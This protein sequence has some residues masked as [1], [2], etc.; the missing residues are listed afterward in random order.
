MDIVTYSLRECDQAISDKYYKRAAVFADEVLREAG[1]VAGSIMQHYDDFLI[2]TKG[3]RNNAEE[4]ILEFLILGVLMRIYGTRALRLKKLQHDVLTWVINK[5]NKD[6]RLKPSMSILKGTMSTLF[7]G[8]SKKLRGVSIT[9]NT[10][11]FSKLILWLEASGEFCNEAKRLRYWEEYINNLSDKSSSDIFA[12]AISFA[13]WFEHR[14]IEVLGEYTSHVDKYLERIIS[15]NAWREDII[16]RERVR[17]EY[18]LNM[19]GAEIMN[20]AFRKAFIS[21]SKKVLLLPLCMTSPGRSLCRAKDFGRSF[22]CAACSDNCQVNQLSKLG[23]EYGFTVMVVPHESSVAASSG[24]DAPF[25]EG[26]GV[27][28][29]ACVL[30]LISGGWLLKDMGVPAQCVLL[31]YCGCRNHWHEKGISTNISIDK[32]KKILDTG[33][34]SI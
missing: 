7:L 27:I 16:F 29:V 17:A 32:L 9:H 19:V 2:N 18:H 28:G 15:R 4:S 8:D 21:T 12:K 3:L 23:E 5:R 14:S 33:N 20:R 26:T 6:D 1:F 30:N 25:D 22:K 10:K 11:S 13:K 34:V 31:D 24:K